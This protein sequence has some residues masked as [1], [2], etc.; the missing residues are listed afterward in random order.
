M[1]NKGQVDMEIERNETV[2][3]QIRHE[4]QSQV[5]PEMRSFSAK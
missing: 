1:K 2:E 5:A 4:H 3:D